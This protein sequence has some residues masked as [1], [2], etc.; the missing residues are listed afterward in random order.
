MATK[1]KK[2]L[3]KNGWRNS[4]DL[5]GEVKI[6]DNTFRIDQHSE[7]SDWTHNQMYLTLYCGEKSGNVTC[8]CNGGFW[9]NRENLIYAYGK[10]END[11]TDYK[12]RVTVAWDDR[13]DEKIL[14]DI[15][16]GSFVRAGLEMDDKGNTF[17]KKFLHTYDFI[18]YIK[19][20]LING[21][22]VR[23]RGNIKYDEYDGKLRVRKEV[24]GI[25]LV[26][27]P[28]PTKY[29]AR[30][31]QTFLVGK[32][33]I[34]YTD[35]KNGVMNV[36]A[37]VLEYYK[38]YRGKEVKQNV[39]IH[40]DM[41][42]TINMGDSEKDSPEKI[43]RFKKANEKLIKE[44]LT[45]K[46]GYNEVRWVGEFVEGGATVQLT[47][48]DLSDDIKMLIMLGVRTKEEALQSVATSSDRVQKMVLL[49]P[50]S[51]MSDGKVSL[52]QPI[53]RKYDEEDLLL[54][55]TEDEDDLPLKLE[56]DAVGMNKPVTTESDEEE[57]DWLAGLNMN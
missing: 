29:Y 52:V 25:Y 56:D 9:V 2:T 27:D 38:N 33:S 53:E 32:D 39:P 10:G 45:A 5:I 57:E 11:T 13:N 19:E 48:D 1:E 50:S 47:E 7:K 41:E 17:T 42:Y 28:D 31:E 23:V 46:K 14:E 51:V 49:Y 16:S 54:D 35:K 12:N 24:K 6:Y 37:I 15:G 20:H 21:A 44:Y 43:E 3:D 8:E 30:F 55:I 22:V 18:K 4:F 26:K 36:D 40:K 34:S